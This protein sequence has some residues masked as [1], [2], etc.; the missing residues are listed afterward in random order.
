M[1]RGVTGIPVRAPLTDA[2]GR[3]LS[4]R[5]PAGVSVLT[6]VGRHA[7][8]D[9]KTDYGLF[10]MQV[11]AVAGQTTALPFTSYLPQIDHAHDVAI[12]SP[13]TSAVVIKS[14]TI[15]GVELHLLSGGIIT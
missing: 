4:A 12:A 9:G 3:F 13:P 11:T 5:V 14:A 6:L 2:E 15:P 10:E 7:S 8:A 1:G